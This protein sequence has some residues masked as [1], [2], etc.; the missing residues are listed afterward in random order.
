MQE[1]ELRR[2]LINLYVKCI[3][4]YTLMSPK[5][6]D[7]LANDIVLAAIMPIAENEK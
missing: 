4:Y 7:W 3:A 5:L 2:L 1:Y 6:D